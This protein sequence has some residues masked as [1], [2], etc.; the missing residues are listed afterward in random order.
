MKRSH[1]TFGDNSLAARRLNLLAS[2][3]DPSSERLLSQVPLAGIQTALDAGC[4][5]G[6]T[7]RLLS[8]VSAAPHTLGF[9]QSPAF[10]DLARANYGADTALEFQCC[11]VL[12]A[13]L[14][15][16]TAQLVFSRFLLTH[17]SEPRRALLNLLDRLAPG[18]HVVLEEVERLDGDTPLLRRYYELVTALQASHGQST[19]IGTELEAHIESLGASVAIASSVCNRLILTGTQMPELHL[20]NIATWRQDPNMES[21]A[22]K[23]ELEQIERGLKALVAAGSAR[24]QCSLRQIVLVKR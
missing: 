12:D 18:G 8:A 21:I 4:G 9:D 15:L 19:T 23:E 13:P 20:M 6:H 22:S 2:T 16:P 17:L 11:S 14:P 1:Y 24:V 5:P 7:T 3:F 10:I